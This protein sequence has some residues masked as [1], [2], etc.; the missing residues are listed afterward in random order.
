M[1]LVEIPIKDDFS[2]REGRFRNYDAAN[3]D[4]REQL[5]KQKHVDIRG[6]RQED[7]SARIPMLYLDLLTMEILDVRTM[8]ELNGNVVV[9]RGEQWTQGTVLKETDRNN[10][11]GLN[12][13]CSVGTTVTQ[14]II[15]V[16]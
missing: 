14:S 10:A 5:Y 12:L 9:R 11:H 8:S 7:L 15:T 3:R 1:Q 4:Q 2:D 6:F 16:A 13:S